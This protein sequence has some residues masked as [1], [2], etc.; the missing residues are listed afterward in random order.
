MI[1]ISHGQ[2]YW[3]FIIPL[4]V[5]LLWFADS[6]VIVA[7]SKISSLLNLGLISTYH[8]VI[9]MGR[10]ARL[11][12]LWF[13]CSLRFKPRLSIV[14]PIENAGEERKPLK[15]QLAQHVGTNRGFLFT[16]EHATLTCLEKK[17][18]KT[19]H[20]DCIQ[21]GLCYKFWIHIMLRKGAILVGGTNKV[22]HQTNRLGSYDTDR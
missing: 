7:L 15:K 3:L 6:I 12:P 20:F 5:E 13:S 17:S 9:C 4:L 8:K 2:I 14:R 21:R 11:A 22:S 1:E 10:C 16:H 19:Q 18:Q